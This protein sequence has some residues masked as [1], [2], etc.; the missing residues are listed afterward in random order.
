MPAQQSSRDALKGVR[1]R[2]VVKEDS[3]DR[4]RTEPIDDCKHGAGRDDSCQVAAR[5]RWNGE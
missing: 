5:C 2:W 1:N 4:N 3:V